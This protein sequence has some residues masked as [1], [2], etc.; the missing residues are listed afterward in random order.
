MPLKKHTEPQKRHLTLE[1]AGQ[2]R[3]TPAEIE[4]LNNGIDFKNNLGITLGQGVPTSTANN[5]GTPRL[6]VVQTG[7]DMSDV[8][9]SFNDSGL[10]TCWDEAFWR[11]VQ[12]GNVFVYTAR[13]AKPCQLQLGRNE[14]GQ[15][16]LSVSRPLETSEIPQREVK[17]PSR[18]Q[19]FWHG[20]YSG[21]YK[22]QVESFDKAAQS[23][24]QIEGTVSRFNEE[25]RD[26]DLIGEV[27]SEILEQRRKEQLERD[28]KYTQDMEPILAE[29]K[30]V[31]DRETFARELF[32][33][34]PV[35]YN[36]RSFGGPEQT[37][38][39]SQPRMN[40]NFRDYRGKDYRIEHGTIKLEDRDFNALGF[41]SAKDPMGAIET[42]SQENMGGKAGLDTLENNVRPAREK[43]REALDVYQDGNRSTP[44][45]DCL[46]DALNKV[47]TMMN[48]QTFPK[49][50][51]TPAQ[52]AAMKM[53]GDLHNL[54][55]NKI[56]NDEFLGAEVQKRSGTTGASYEKYMAV[57]KGYAEF[58]RLND[59][60][61][62]ARSKL[63]AAEHENIDLDTPTRMG[64][65]KDIVKA[66]LAEQILTDELQTGKTAFARALG[67]QSETL[68]QLASNIIRLDNRLKDPE[69][70]GSRLVESLGKH[71]FS[72]VLQNVSASLS[73]G[74]QEDMNVQIGE[75]VRDN[76]LKADMV[77]PVV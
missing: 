76:A 73:M 53:A 38:D 72:N 57:A 21:F 51:F 42:L 1:A 77:G 47:A 40:A 39:W 9:K 48:G 49:G 14:K 64:Y 59:A 37:G 17:K 65:V 69:K 35:R 29:R 52:K 55:E 27:D 10:K 61:Q 58:A 70:T 34:K 60:A 44:L 43:I 32:S 41:F 68:D 3:L 18:W 50:R 56:K 5:K 45:L 67:S 26:S 22:E 25:R 23:K 28:K 6:F 8:A 46:A 75:A 19:R 7:E 33:M 12:M 62:N 36:I 2:R 16:S 15:L 30:A 13:S 31:R 63:I 71:D 24:S 4:A 66:E 74:V 11:Q 20:I 54:M